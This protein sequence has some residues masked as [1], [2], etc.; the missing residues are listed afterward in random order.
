MSV[1]RGEDRRARD[2]LVEAAL[3]S[4]DRRREALL[5]CDREDRIIAANDRADAMLRVARG[6]LIGRPL[7]D[8]VELPE[9]ARDGDPSSPPAKDRPT[10]TDCGLLNVA[11]ASGEPLHALA[12]VFRLGPGA[13]DPLCVSLLDPS[14]PEALARELDDALSLSAAIIREMPIGVLLRSSSGA[15]LEANPA[16]KTLL[17]LPAAQPIDAGPIEPP[18]RAF[19][20]DDV[21]SPAPDAPETALAQR[22]SG[23]LG[24]PRSDGDITWLDVTSRPLGATASV[25]FSTLVD[26]TPARRAELRATAMQRRFETLS[27]LSTEAV[28]VL[29]DR[30]AITAASPNAPRVL[31]LRADQLLG[32]PLL[33]CVP[34]SARAEAHRALRDLLRCEGARARWDLTLDASPDGPRTFEL[35]GINLR[36]D[37]SVR[38]IAL[39]LR[40]IHEQRVAEAALRDA[41]ELLERRLQQLGHDRVIDAAMSRVAELMQHCVNA[42]ETHEVVWGSLPVLLPGLDA[43]LYFESEDGLEFSGHRARDPSCAF[44]QTDMCWALRTRRT[45]VSDHRVHLRCEHLKEDTRFSICLPLAVGGRAFGLIVVTPRALTDPLPDVEDLDR[46]AARLSIACGNSRHVASPAG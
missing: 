45:H 37:P 41:N 3:A 22:S 34:A 30:L 4:V 31:G 15:V 26:V 19:S 36:G 32:R 38:G 16:A 12:R 14:A 46:L 11:S 39:N 1:E 17:G 25:R 13:D 27:G 7:R 23:W 6:A 29:D 40:D 8:F 43:A 5:V 28:L 24:V 18:W 33:E 35:R 2:V 44:L 10:G 9:R 21:P 20:P 42:H